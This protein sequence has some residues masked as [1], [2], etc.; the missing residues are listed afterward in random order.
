MGNCFGCTL[1][2]KCIGLFVFLFIW[3]IIILLQLIVDIFITKYKTYTERERERE[4]DT[5]IM[6]SGCKRLK[7]SGKYN[8]CIKVNR[9]VYPKSHVYG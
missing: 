6:K 3:S 1:I 8:S 7:I 5:E 4:R 2:R 9:L